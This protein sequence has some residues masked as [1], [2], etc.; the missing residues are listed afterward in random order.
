M[1]K[2]KRGAYQ[3]LMFFAGNKIYTDFHRNSNRRYIHVCNQSAMKLLK[4]TL[5]TLAIIVGSMNVY[6]SIPVMAAIKANQVPLPIPIL[7]PFT[8]YDTNLGIIVNLS[9]QM[10][11]ASVGLAGNLGI[12]VI[13]CILKN[14]V[15]VS[16]VV[17]GHSIDEYAK[18]IEENDPKTKLHSNQYFRNILVQVQDL[19]RYVLNLFL[20][21]FGF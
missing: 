16:T 8:T 13:T 17:V 7:V 19:D 1:S 11:T 10:F 4:N 5:A 18:V 15:W 6:V 20:P 2:S 3:S 21:Y 14:T 12:E 9:N